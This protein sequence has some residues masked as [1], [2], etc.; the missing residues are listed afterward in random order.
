M[1]GKRYGQMEALD[2]LEKKRG[3]VFPSRK[4]DLKGGRPMK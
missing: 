4:A 3:E 1:K 2:R